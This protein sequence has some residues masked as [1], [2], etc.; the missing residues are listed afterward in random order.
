[1]KVEHLETIKWKKTE[2][3]C[4]LG[5]ILQVCKSGSCPALRLKKEP[6][7]CGRDINDLLGKGSYMSQRVLGQLHAVGGTWQA[8]SGSHLCYTGEKRL[9][10][11]GGT[12]ISWAH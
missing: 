12:D 9:P 5:C 1:M 7:K 10:F 3:I 2:L 4:G 11:I 8:G 6:E